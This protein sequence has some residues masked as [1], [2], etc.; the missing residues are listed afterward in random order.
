MSNRKVAGRT[1][2]SRGEPRDD[3]KLAQSLTWR[4]AGKGWRL[5]AGKRRFGDVV[6]DAKHPNMWRS[7]LSGGRLSDM[8]NLSWARNAVLESA[9]REIEWEERQQAAT[10]PAFIRD[11][12]A[13]F[14]ATSSQG[15]LT[16]P[17]DPTDTGGAP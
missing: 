8:A 16:P 12:G 15:D 10:D 4:K 3:S 11:S 5:Y 13:V 6:P 1:L 2:D 9:V 14:E 7:I 17:D